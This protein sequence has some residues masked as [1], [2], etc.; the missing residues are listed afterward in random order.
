MRVSGSKR[1]RSADSAGEGPAGGSLATRAW[2]RSEAIRLKCAMVVIV[3]PGPCARLGSYIVGDDEPPGGHGRSCP[4]GG[5]LAT[6]AWRRSEAVRLKCAM[7]VIVRPGT[8]ARLGSHI[9]GDDEPPGGH[10]RSC[11]AGGSLAPR[12]WRRSEA[13]WLKCAIM[14]VVRP[15]SCARLGSHIVGDDEPPGGHGRSCPAG[16][17]LAPRGWRRSEAVRLKCAIMVVVRPGSC[18]RLGSHIVEDDE[19][20]AGQS[21][22]VWRSRGHHHWIRPGP[23]SGVDAAEASHGWIGC[24]GWSRHRPSSHRIAS[25]LSRHP[26]P[27]TAAHPRGTGHR[28]AG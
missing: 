15:G 22:G 26:T 17:S 1:R 4:A 18:A 6:R 27:R 7:V 5:S 28:S 10:G 19:P 12:A 20:P 25:I 2:R 11:P 16:G 24:F 3:R 23:S 13:V 9:V 21:A 8:C 14:V